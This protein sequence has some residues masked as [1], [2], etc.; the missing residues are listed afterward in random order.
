MVFCANEGV[1]TAAAAAAA[2][3]IRLFQV[4]MTGLRDGGRR[5]G[6]WV[7]AQFVICKCPRSR[8]L[9]KHVGWAKSPAAADDMTHWPRATLPTRSNGEVGRR[10][11]NRRRGLFKLFVDARRFYP[12]YRSRRRSIS[13]FSWP[14]SISIMVPL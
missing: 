1:V 13:D 6:Q 3:G 7:P 8:N 4:F 10:G 9:V 12:P 2:S 11:Q 5:D 14:P